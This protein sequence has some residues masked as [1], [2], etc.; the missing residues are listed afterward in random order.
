[1]NT[2]G[3]TRHRRRQ[4]L[5]I[6]AFCCSNSACVRRP[7]VQQLPELREVGEPLR[8]GVQLSR[9]GGRLL[10]RRW[11]LIGRILTA[12]G[13]LI[14]AAPSDAHLRELLDSASPQ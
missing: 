1:M 9:S 5:R 2:V 3:G 6:R 8:R 12:G 13:M 10:L 14:I 7:G 4:L 11:W